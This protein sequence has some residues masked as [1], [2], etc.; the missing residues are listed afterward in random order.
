V[1]IVSFVFDL[2]DLSLPAVAVDESY[3]SSRCW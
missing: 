3:S 2:L 1:F